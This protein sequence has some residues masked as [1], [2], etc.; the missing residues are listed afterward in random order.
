MSNTLY[1]AVWYEGKKQV[2]QFFV[3]KEKR[4]QALVGKALKPPGVWMVN[5]EDVKI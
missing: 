5:S 2:I 1:Y 3:N 4:D